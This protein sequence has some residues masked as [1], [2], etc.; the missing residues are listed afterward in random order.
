MYPTEFRTTGVGWSIGMGRLGGIIGP[1][2]G[3]IL[4]GMG[5]TMVQNFLIY[6]IPTLLAG[7]MTMYISSKEIR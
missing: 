2:A 5:L 1:A 3:G 7:I 4:I 6:A